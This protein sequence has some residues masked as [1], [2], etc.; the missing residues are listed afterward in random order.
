MTAASYIALLGVVRTLQIVVAFVFCC[1]VKYVADSTH[2]R[3][4]GVAEKSLDS[5]LTS[6]LIFLGMGG[7]VSSASMREW[8]EVWGKKIN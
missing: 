8:S 2:W 5:Q 3:R 4:C 1:I 6:S 7:V